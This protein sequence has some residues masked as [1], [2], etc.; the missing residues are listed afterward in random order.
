MRETR[1]TSFP[2]RT[3]ALAIERRSSQGLSAGRF[4][5]VLGLLLSTLCSPSR[6]AQ[7]VTLAWNA[8]SEP[9]IAGYR[10]YCQTAAEDSSAVVDVGNPTTFTLPN[11]G[12]GIA[13]LFTVTAYNGA[14][15]ESLPSNAVLFNAGALADTTLLTVNSGA[16]GGSYPVGAVVTVSANSSTEGSHFAGWSGDVAILSD[17]SAST[18]TATIPSLDVAITATYSPGGFR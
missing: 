16:G 10:I 14:L 17:A 7:S 8:N 3:P 18:T 13:Y 6:A 15:L 12:A 2:A 11:L 5:G 4:I 1:K 9:D